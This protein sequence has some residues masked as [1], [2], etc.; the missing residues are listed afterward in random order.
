MERIKLY[1]EFLNEKINEGIGD[2]IKG[3]AKTAAK[4]AGR[5]AM[6][7]IGGDKLVKLADQIQKNKEKKA[8]L[9]KKAQKVSKTNKPTTDLEKNLVVSFCLHLL[10]LL[11]S[12]KLMEF[13]L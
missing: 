7:Y 10:C 6:K 3:V 2:A 4:K 9:A 5:A 8:K 12:P 1:E 11:I 13:V